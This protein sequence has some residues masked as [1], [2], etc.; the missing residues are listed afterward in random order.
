MSLE[1]LPPGSRSRPLP[2]YITPSLQM[3]IKSLPR[4]LLGAALLGASSFSLSAGGAKASTVCNF[5]NPLTPCPANSKATVDD[6]TLTTISGP[7]QGKGVVDFVTYVAG[8]PPRETYQVDVDFELPGPLVGAAG[9]TTGTF[10]YH[11][12]IDPLKQHIFETA[13]LSWAGVASPNGAPSVLKQLYKTS[14]MDPGD[15]FASLTSN[16]STVNFVNLALKDI[17]VK[18]T[19]TVP[20]GAQ[21]DNFENTYTQV[22]GPLPLL[23]AGTAFGFSRRLRRRSA[24]ARMSLG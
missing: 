9:G 18:D 23:G 15:L 11:L 19:Y 5:D 16:G 13:S 21:L 3:T 12:S 4:L 6:K 2:H 17:W 1:S 8:S 7:D 10:S 20:E 14:A 24:K 22:P